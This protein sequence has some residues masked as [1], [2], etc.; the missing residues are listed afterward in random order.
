MAAQVVSPPWM[1]SHAHGCPLSG[2]AGFASSCRS[3]AQLT[4]KPVLRMPPGYSV[5]AVASRTDSGEI[6]AS[7]GGRSL[8]VNSWLIPP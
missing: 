5:V 8:A 7:D 1:R 3:W 6:A 2:P 4:A